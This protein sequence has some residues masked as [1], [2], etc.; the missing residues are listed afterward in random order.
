MSLVVLERASLGYGKKSLF[1]ALDLRIG[2]GDRM[3][4]V[5][6]NGSGKTSL[7]RVLAGEQSLDE[8]TLRPQKSLRVGYLPQDIAL[9]G[10]RT[11]L[12]FVISSVPGREGLDTAADDAQR[13]LEELQL[14]VEAG[15]EDQTEALMQL[16]QLLAE[17]HERLAHFDTHYSA[18]QAGRILAGL[19]FVASDHDR[20]LGELSG[21]W[22]MRALLAALLFQQPDLLL[23]DE[24]TN[25]LDMPSVAWLG[26]FLRGYGGA[27]VLICHDREFLNEQIDRVVSFESEGVRQYSGNYE[28]YRRQRAEEEVVLENEAKNAARER[29][30]AEQF[31]NRF[32]AQANKAKAV[33]SRVKALARMADVQ[34]FRPRSVMRFRFPP[35]DRSG[36]HVLK[37]DRLGKSYGDHHVLAEVDLTVQRG[38]KI[39]IIGANGAGKTTLLKILADELPASGG[40]VRMGNKVYTG[41]Y[42]QHHTESLTPDH[43]IY[44]EVAQRNPDAGQTRVRGMLGAFLFTGDDVD[45]KV[46]VL[47]GGERSR[48]ALA[49]LLIHPGNL[50]LMD[51]PTN[52]LD[53]ESS[54]SLAESLKSYDGTLIF[55]SHN[56]SFVRQLATRIWNVAGGTVETYPGTLDEYLDASSMDR[57][58]ETGPRTA[59]PTRRKQKKKR[60]ATRPGGTQPHSSDASAGEHG[61][62]DPPTAPHKAQSNAGT[63]NRADA[64]SEKRQQA[65]LRGEYRKTIGPLEQ[66]VQGLERKISSIEAEQKQRN[67]DL[68]D[69][70][71]YG[72]ATRRSQLLS[73]F[74]RAA[75]DLEHLNARWEVA[76]SALE[77][78]RTAFEARGQ[79]RSPRP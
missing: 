16:A 29:E 59:R 2:A 33:Q 20:D 30:K 51:E 57:E 56:R 47:S 11:V 17:L 4:L 68:A 31:I 42:A 78:A 66:T 43:T 63:K 61:P 37:I 44:E 76:E 55:V 72:D 67:I 79:P 24:P 1:S 10:G 54:E 62:G 27:F 35:C 70:D 58:G 71:C 13:E 60:S 77:S 12:D 22:K 9:D 19:G 8:G 75:H 38:E 39:G 6:P 69:P 28:H 40:E 14:R 3:G 48:V 50:L 7:L 18:H 41:Y 21:G 49:R 74:Q 34:L 65:Q 45:K 32:R 23:L 64:R 46:R 5:G 26:D 36:D 73:A 52:H 15:A 53:L 25:H